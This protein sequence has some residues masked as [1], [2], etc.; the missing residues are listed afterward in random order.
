MAKKTEKLPGELTD[1]R[2]K[3]KKRKYITP[4]GLASQGKVEEAPKLKFEYNP[5]LAPV[6][7]VK[8]HEN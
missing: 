1:Y 4:A 8:L 3:D 6:L 7:S 2:F 5:H